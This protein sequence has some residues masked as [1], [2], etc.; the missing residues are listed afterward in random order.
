[1]A[2]TPSLLNPIRL[3]IP[4][5]STKRKRRLGGF[6]GWGLGVTVPISIKPNPKEESSEKSSAFLSSPAAKPT[7]LGN[8]IP[9]TSLS[10][11]L[12]FNL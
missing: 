2:S 12:S 9:K 11:R 10:K 5:S 3:M 7:E 8:F 1:M 4:S 6:P